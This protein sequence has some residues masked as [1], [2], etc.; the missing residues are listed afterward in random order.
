MSKAFESI[1]HDN[2]EASIKDDSG[3]VLGKADAKEIVFKDF[4]HKTKLALEN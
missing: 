1:C 4:A 3:L 2:F